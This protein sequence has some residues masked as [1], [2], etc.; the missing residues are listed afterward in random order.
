[1]TDQTR[2]MLF[3]K[4]RAGDVSLD[5]APRSGRPV[6]VDSDEVDTFIENNQCVTT[7]ERADLLEISQSIK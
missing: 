1:M 4:F 3:A 5:N 2:P 7:Q 6:E